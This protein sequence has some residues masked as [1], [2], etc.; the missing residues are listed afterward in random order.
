MEDQWKSLF[1]FETISQFSYYSFRS[2]SDRQIR[3]SE[4]HNIPI[5]KFEYVTN[6]GVEQQEQG[7]FTI[8]YYKS[9]F[10]PE[11]KKFKYIQHDDTLKED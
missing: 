4:V 8:K 10:F 3:K 7:T 9:M 2:N 6:I 1:V 5:D 11:H